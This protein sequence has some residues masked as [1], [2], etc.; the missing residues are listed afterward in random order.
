LGTSGAERP[1][2]SA[3]SAAK[4]CGLILAGER[5]AR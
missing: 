4:N 2:H 3:R 1:D 5:L